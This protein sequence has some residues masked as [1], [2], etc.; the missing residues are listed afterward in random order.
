MS[1]AVA[2]ARRSIS[3]AVTE[4][5]LAG[6]EDTMRN[7]LGLWKMYLLENKEYGLSA[8]DEAAYRAEHSRID[9]L[10]KEIFPEREEAV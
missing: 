2:A 9:W 1:E 10:L 5:R 3:E 6:C 4:L 8:A 7:A